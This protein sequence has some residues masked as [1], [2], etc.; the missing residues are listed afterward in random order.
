MVVDV[1]CSTLKRPSYSKSSED[2][3]KR[4]NELNLRR[5]LKTAVSQVYLDITNDNQFLT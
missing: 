5:A 2:R 4:M 3:K 1:K